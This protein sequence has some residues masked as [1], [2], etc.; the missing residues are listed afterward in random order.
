[1]IDTLK[2]IVKNPTDPLRAVQQIIDQNSDLRK[3]IELF[4]HEKAGQLK[5]ELLKTVVS[6]NGINFISS[7]VKI[8]TAAIKELAFDLR[9]S[10]ER[11]FLVLANESEGKAGLTVL[12]A[13]ELVTERK[14]NAGTIVRELAKNIQGG[15]GGQPNF[16]TAGGKNPD[17]IPAALTQ[18]RNFL[19]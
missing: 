14:L 3:Q 10:V 16:A 12:L 5:S 15:G 18:A 1:M 8:D 11:L 17:G 4:N 7:I 19:V 9:N 13:D 2:T 6:V